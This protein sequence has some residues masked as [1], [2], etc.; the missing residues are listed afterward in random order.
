MKKLLRK[1]LGIEEDVEV[2]MAMINGIHEDY[3]TKNQVQTIISE[4]FQKKYNRPYFAAVFKKALEATK[5]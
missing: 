1:W 5:K 3:L 2:F 4:T